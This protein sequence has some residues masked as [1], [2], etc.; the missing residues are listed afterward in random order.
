MN[1]S[2]RVKCYIKNGGNSKRCSLN[3]VHTKN[4]EGTNYLDKTE[5][6]RQPGKRPRQDDQSN[7]N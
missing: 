6:V 5:M 7:L 2:E 1:N 4:N 3:D